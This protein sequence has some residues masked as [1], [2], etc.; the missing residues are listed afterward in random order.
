MTGDLNLRCARDL[1]PGGVIFIQGY[2][3]DLLEVLH[4][5]PNA[6]VLRWGFDE[7]DSV[8]VWDNRVFAVVGRM[9]C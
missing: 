9:P 5:E 3:A 8:A 7:S 1:K 4:A 6:T 2:P